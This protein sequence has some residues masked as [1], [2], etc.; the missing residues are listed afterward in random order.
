MLPNRLFRRLCHYHPVGNSKQT[1][2]A[3]FEDGQAIKRIADNE[4]LTQLGKNGE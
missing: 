3:A 4:G 1:N 2:T